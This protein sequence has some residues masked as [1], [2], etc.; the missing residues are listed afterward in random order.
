MSTAISGVSIKGQ[1]VCGRDSWPTIRISKTSAFNAEV[2]IQLVEKDNDAGNLPCPSPNGLYL[3]AIKDVDPGLEF[4]ISDK[5]VVHI[6]SDGR[7]DGEKIWILHLL[8]F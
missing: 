3:K 6:L 8:S 7:T 5:N 4:P 2:W 1:K